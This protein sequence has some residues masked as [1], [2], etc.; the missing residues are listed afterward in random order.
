M[1]SESVSSVREPVYQ[2][3]WPLGKSVIAPAV[4]PSPPIVDL[5]GKTIGELW[6]WLFKGPEIFA[7]VRQRLLERFP[8][9]KFVDHSVFGNIHGSRE[10]EVIA[11]LPEMLRQHGCDAVIAAVGA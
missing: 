3:V 9:V 5:N 10:A 6:D 2:V 8:D 1:R 4:A 11:A 7:I